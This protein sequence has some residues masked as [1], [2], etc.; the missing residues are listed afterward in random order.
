MSGEELELTTFQQIYIQVPE[1]KLEFVKEK[2]KEVG[3][4]CYPVGNFVKSLR[5]CNFYKGSEEE[6]MPVAIELNERISGKPVPFTLRPAYTGC[7][8]G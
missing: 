6:G 1:N 5:T 2:F 3:L 7:Q 8:V 4:S